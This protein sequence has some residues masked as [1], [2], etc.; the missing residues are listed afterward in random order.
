ML[1]GVGIISSDWFVV[2]ACCA[3]VFV[4][5]SCGLYVVD[6]VVLR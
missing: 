6:F 3:G 5:P 2:S 4:I 1:G